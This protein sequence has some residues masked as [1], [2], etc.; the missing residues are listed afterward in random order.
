M[1]AT[2]LDDPDPL[3]F[4]TLVSSIV[5]VVAPSGSSRQDESELSRPAQEL[6]LES[7]VE[8]KTRET[9]AML[10][11]LAALV[12]DNRMAQQA[13]REMRRRDHALP[14]WLLTFAAVEKPFCPW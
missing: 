12:P 6:F 8:I 3:A 13:R 10:H 9:T 4:L 11:G 2:A 5:A 1:V 14:H 7:M